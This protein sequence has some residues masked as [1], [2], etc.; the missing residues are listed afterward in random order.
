[1]K[2]GLF[3]LTLLFLVNCGSPKIP[4]T[5][6][7]DTGSAP[8]DTSEPDDG[9]T[10]GVVF[11]PIRIQ[12][13]SLTFDDTEVGSPTSEPWTVTN[14]SSEPIALSNIFAEGTGFNNGGE[15]DFPVDLNSGDIL[16]GTVVFNPPAEGAF[17]GLLKIGVAGQ[18]GY[19]E[20]IL[21]GNGIPEGSAD[22]TGD[23]DP[24]GVLTPFPESIEFG[25][26]A[27]G[28]TAWRTLQLTNTSSTDVLIERIDSLS[29]YVFESAPDFS[30]PLNLSSGQTQ[31]VQVGF[32]P[33]ELLEY[34]AV[35]EITANVEGGTLM[36]PLTGIGND[37]GCTT[38]APV[39]NTYT[40]SGSTETL[41][42]SPPS[43]LGCTANGS[44]SITNTGD[45]PLSLTDVYLNNDSIS[46][47]G[48]FTRTWLGAE[49][50]EPGASTT[51]G[52]DY[53]ASSPCIEG[54]YPGTD[55]NM[56][57]ILSSDPDRPDVAIQLEGDA[58]YCGG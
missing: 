27:V 14:E 3:L 38:C 42:M 30:V 56:L 18:E 53:V 15:D 28:E 9:P 37:S 8:V 51:V 33:L 40:S 11:G 31:T 22:D 10:T 24:T 34:T 25:T 12:P 44:I 13:G 2:H 4:G 54:A 21:R 5:P 55:Q 16:T 46:T 35:L 47:C 43:G 29:P 41:T 26:F 50:I 32:S 39:I 57:H 58:L 19:G 17:S 23:A 45:L 6:Q 20:L 49:T 48:E 52:V 1:M 36:V 7:N